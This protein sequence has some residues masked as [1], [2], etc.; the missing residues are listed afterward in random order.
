MLLLDKPQRPFHGD[1]WFHIGEYYLSQRHVIEDMLSAQSFDHLVIVSS[2]W[3]FFSVLSQFTFFL[4]LLC[5][6]PKQFKSISLGYTKSTA[7]LSHATNS[8][9]SFAAL[10][11]PYGYQREG[12]LQPEHE[13]EYLCYHGRI[14][15]KV[16]SV[17]VGTD[18]WFNSSHPAQQLQARIAAYCPASPTPTADEREGKYKMIFY[19]R[20][21]NRRMMNLPSVLEGLRLRSPH[22]VFVIA[23]HSE[24]R[25]PCAL[26]HLMQSAD[27]LVTT[28][29]F[30]MMS[31]LFLR[32]HAHVLE[33]FPHKYFKPT[34]QPLARALGLR[35]Q[36]VYG[37]ADSVYP[38][39]NMWS[40]MHA[41]WVLPR[42]GLRE[43]MQD[44]RC[45][46]L[47]RQQDVLLR[48]QDLRIVRGIM[49]QVEGREVYLFV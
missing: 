31:M 38:S 35:H 37:S 8:S 20:D 10:P 42:V 7:L 12:H 34:Y 25:A 27:V 19:Q 6:P 33:H 14:A 48:E 39:D 21:R 13:E 3:K 11:A 26:F 36:W 40:A 15:G 1:H 49:Q 45:R 24:Q 28:H 17:P 23:Q 22:W 30:Q 29:G 41:Q 5:V 18:L 44:M 46:S 32:P 16:G 2:N 9:V 4:L 43:C 47:A